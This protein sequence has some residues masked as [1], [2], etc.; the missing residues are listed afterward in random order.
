MD[1]AEVELGLRAQAQLAQRRI[2]RFVR[3]LARHGQMKPVERTSE[4]GRQRGP[5]LH[6]L[7]GI[8]RLLEVP[9]SHVAVTEVV[10]EVDVVRH[11]A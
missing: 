7:G 9:A 6:E 2:V 8:G 5:D 3:A 4:A 11:V 1:Q 10:S